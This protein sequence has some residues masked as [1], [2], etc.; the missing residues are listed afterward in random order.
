MV[1]GVQT[2]A[3]PICK[4]LKNRHGF[5]TFEVRDG[6]NPAPIDGTI[7]ELYEK[8]VVFDRVNPHD[9]VTVHEYGCVA[10]GAPSRTVLERMAKR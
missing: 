3:L 1:T 5:L 9:T 10:E 6:E 2:C 8:A 7:P 4:R